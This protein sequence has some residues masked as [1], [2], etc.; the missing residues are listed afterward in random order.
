MTG[1]AGK[2]YVFKKN[3]A[4]GGGDREEGPSATRFRTPL[5]AAELENLKNRT[6]AE[7]MEKK[8]QWAVDM[9]KQWWRNR[10]SKDCCDMRIMW[11]DLSNV[12][13]I[14]KG[15]LA[16]S[17]CTFISEVN[18]VNGGGE[19]PGA[20]LYQIVICTQFFLQKNGINWKLLDDP[21]FLCLHY[22]LDNV[23]KERA[24]MGLGQK[25]SA[26]VISVTDEE[27]MWAEGVLGELSPDQLRETVMYLLGINLALR[28]GGGTLDTS[29]SWSQISNLNPC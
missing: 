8:V 19:Y 2:Q 29:L 5:E 26:Q 11:G 1:G 10:V 18:K 20:T 15:N 7:N 21:D 9:F 24:K 25:K 14:S 16:Y 3:I 12:E 28:G 17:L 6:F 4:Q 13:Q 27:K 22:T 23:M